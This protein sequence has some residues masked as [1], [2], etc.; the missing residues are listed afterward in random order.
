MK[1]L[2]VSVLSAMKGAIKYH[3]LSSIE[4][5]LVSYYAQMNI[6]CT[7]EQYQRYLSH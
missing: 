7:L 4:L 5:I 3:V 2:S 6:L 1:E